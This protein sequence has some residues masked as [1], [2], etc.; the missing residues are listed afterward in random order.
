MG[1]IAVVGFVLD[2]I[3]NDD[4]LG[5]TTLTTPISDSSETILTTPVTE[6]TNIDTIDPVPESEGLGF[7]TRKSFI[8]YMDY[9]QKKYGLSDDQREE[10]HR[11]MSKKGFSPEEIEER[12]ED[13][14]N[15]SNCR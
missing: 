8:K 7:N 2:Q 9:V 6:P 15:E 13:M 14:S 10:L 4:D 5:S 3:L 12:A 11:E 1:A